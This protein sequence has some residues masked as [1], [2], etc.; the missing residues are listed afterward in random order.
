MTRT[1]TCTLCG[2]SCA[3][4][5]LSPLLDPHLTWLWQQVAAAADHRADPELTSGTLRVTAPQSAAERAAAGGLLGGQPLRPGQQRTVTLERLTAKVRLR[6]PGLTPGSVA[7]HAVS[8]PLATKAR[9]KAAREAFA[10]ALRE[11]LLH[12][13]QQLPAHVRTRLAADSWEQLRRSGWLARLLKD[14]DP[15]ALLGDACRVLT[16]LPEPGQRTDRRTLV[17]GRPHALDA[18][19]T[20]AGLVLALVGVNARRPRQAWDELGVDID[21]LTGG[22]LALGIHPAGWTLPPTAVV[23]LPP[24]ELAE[25]QWNPAPPDQWVF[26]TENPSVVAAAADLARDRGAVLRMLCTVGTPSAVETA[27]VAKLIDVGWKVAVRA[28]FDAAGLAHVRA[29]L[30]AA[31]AATPWRMAAADYRASVTPSGPPGGITVDMVATPWAP[32]LAEAM[33]DVGRP[34]FE[35]DLMSTLLADLLAGRPHPLEGS[36]DS[37]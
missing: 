25:V 6:G 10:E 28:D 2:G 11:Q 33:T 26:V 35:E 27:A 34:A 36:G 14:P 32:D 37:Y 1:V 12:G 31:P 23:T 15:S 4:A 30:A 20:L 19:T 8:R 9:E 18:G 3:A 22:L 17:P 16:G 24:R 29:L 7:A 21:N 5:D 13:Q